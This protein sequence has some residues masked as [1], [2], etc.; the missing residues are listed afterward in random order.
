MKINAEFDRCFEVNMLENEVIQE[1]K[2]EDGTAE[3]DIKP[4]EI[5]TLKFDIRS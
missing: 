1:L 5:K 4:F 2:Y 3:F